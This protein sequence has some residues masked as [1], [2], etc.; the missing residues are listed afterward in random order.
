MNLDPAGGLFD[1][2]PGIVGSP[3]LDEGQPQDTQAPEV[4]HSYAGHS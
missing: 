3:A 4:V 1:G 2:L